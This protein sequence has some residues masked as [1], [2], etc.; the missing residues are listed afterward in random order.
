MSTA[1]AIPPRFWWLVRLTIAG[2][3]LLIILLALR[4]WGG[5]AA[6]HHLDAEIAAAQARGELVL[7]DDFADPSADHPSD[8]QNAAVQYT[9]AGAAINYNAAQTAFDNRF[10]SDTAL[11]DSD[12]KIL[13]GLIAAN[14]R[15][16]SLCRTAADLPRANWGLKLHSPVVNVLLPALNWQRGLANIL[17]YAAVDH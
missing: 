4:L 17:Q 2:A 5:N 8:A 13:D 3:L 10:S 11:S 7:I 1:A 12:R 14:A 6:Q 16:I 9:A 15:T